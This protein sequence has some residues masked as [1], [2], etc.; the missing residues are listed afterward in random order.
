MEFRRK[1][2]RKKEAK[3]TKGLL[4]IALLGLAILLWFKM[5]AILEA[6]F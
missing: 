6:L 5:E 4:F 2:G 1:F 3:P